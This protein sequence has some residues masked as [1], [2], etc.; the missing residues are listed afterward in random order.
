MIFMITEY[1]SVVTPAAGALTV[2]I[3]LYILAQLIIMKDK[4]V[5][6]VIIINNHSMRTFSTVKNCQIQRIYIISSSSIQD[7][8]WEEARQCYIEAKKFG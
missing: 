7:T 3:T 4:K 1:I 2:V 6:I 5:C 8:Q